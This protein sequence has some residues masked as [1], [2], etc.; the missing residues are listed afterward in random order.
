MKFRKRQLTRQEKEQ[1]LAKH[2]LRC[3]VDGAPI[4]DKKEIEFHH[5]VPF[6]QDG[7]TTVDNIAPVC[8]KHHRTIGTMSLQ[9]YRDKLELEK[10]FGDGE[11][12]YLDDVV[13]ARKGKCGEPIQY[14][15]VA[16]N[17][18]KIFLSDSSVELPLYQCP[19]TNWQYFYAHIPVEHLE[20]DAELQPRALRKH[21]MWNLYRHF[22]SHTQLS[23]SICRLDSDHVP[24][25]AN[26]G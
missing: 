1:V 10:F 17:R 3:F 13:K 25:C 22:V 4:P 23:P 14:E 26:I 7:S 16:N 8:R 21:S 11:Q 9:E 5:I 24:L 18:I 12:K 19:V 15:I 2:G 20:N 6:S